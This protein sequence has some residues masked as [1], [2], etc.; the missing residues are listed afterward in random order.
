MN[1]SMPGNPGRPAPLISASARVALLVF[2]LLLARPSRGGELDALTRPSDFRAMRESSSNEDLSRNGDARSIEP[3][4]TLVLADIEGPGVITHIWSTVASYDPFYPRSLVLRIHW[5][6]NEHPGVVAPLGDFF[7]VGNGA[8]ADLDSVPVSVS[9]DGRARNCFWR[10]PFRKSARVTVTNESD[11]Y[12]TDSFYYYLDWQ[13]HETLPEDTLYFHAWYRQ[14]AP[15]KPG[16]YT[17]LETEGRGHYVGTVQSVHQVEIG[18]FGEG[19]DWF[20]IDGE[21]TPS[22]RG[23]GTEDYFGDAWGF[24]R[25]TNAY[26]GVSVWEGYFPGDRVTAYRWHIPDPIPFTRSLKVKIEHRG[27]VFND[28]GLQ[29]GSFVERPDWVSS[30]A[31]WYQTPALGIAEPLPPAADRLAPWIILGPEDL[32]VTVVPDRG[33]TKAKEGFMY[34][35]RHETPRI[36][37]SFEVAEKGR[38]RIDAVLLHS[39][40][41]GVYQPMLDGGRIGEPIDFC[42]SG[43]DPLPVRLDLHDLSAGRHTL[44][45]E[46]LGAS[47]RKRSATPMVNA[48]GLSYITLLRLESMAGYRE[49]L[50]AQMRSR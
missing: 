6:G 2:G 29:L 11:K 3:G 19:D 22:L 47:P 28:L 24:R 15:A 50:R 13:K 37:F 4:G 9:S 34:L 32:D 1:T 8:L 36:E 12:R 48:F 25:F 30:V 7:G 16:D 27:S 26:H 39:I 38:Y 41:A 44:A 21:E 10:M 14:D 20:F 35:P 18:W 17:I 31:F 33:L 40:F 46:G 5:D 49:A 43:H 23:T 42:R 45:F